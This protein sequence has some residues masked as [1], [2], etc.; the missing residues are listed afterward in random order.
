MLHDG[1]R[2]D[3][4]GLHTRRAALGARLDE[5]AAMFAAGE[6]DASQLRR[7][8][9]DLRVQL[10][11]VDQVLAEL[12]RRSP[13]ADLLAAGDKLRQYWDRLSPD[14]KGKVVQEIC[15]VTVQPARRGTRF[16]YNLIDIDWRER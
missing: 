4:D 13:V 11:D 2:V 6:I 10:A 16:D 3:V 12:S 5:L 14:M 9:N 15:T 8:T 7:G 1:Q